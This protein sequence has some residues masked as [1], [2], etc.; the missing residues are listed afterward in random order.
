MSLPPVM[1]KAR[2]PPVKEETVPLNSES[3][4][5]GL[6]PGVV[7]SL[8]PMAGVRRPP[9]R[10]TG[11]ALRGEAVCGQCP[12][13]VG[14]SSSWVAGLGPASKGRSEQAPAWKM[15]WR[16]GTRGSLAS[17]A[18]GPSKQG[19]EGGASSQGVQGQP[20]RRWDWRG[21]QDP[22]QRRAFPK[23]RRPRRLRSDTSLPG[24]Q[25]IPSAETT[26]SV[27]SPWG[28][29]AAALPFPWL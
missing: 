14:H 25:R 5:P 20:C 7:L 24:R 2:P 8:W 28:A 26:S 27:P 23:G 22:G 10:G 6:S 21:F 3:R 15:V 11:Q 12:S 1:K 29:S 4:W 13:C 9:Y 18:L 17:G 19:Q 16:V